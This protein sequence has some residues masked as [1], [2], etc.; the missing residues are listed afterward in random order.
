MSSPLRRQCKITGVNDSMC[1]SKLKELLGQGFSL[2]SQEPPPRNMIFK[3]ELSAPNLAREVHLEIFTNE[4]CE[5]KASRDIANNFQD[6]CSKIET[7][8]KEAVNIVSRGTSMRAMR[9]GRILEYLRNLS[10]QDEVNR[11]VIVTLCDVVLDLIVT[12]KLSTFRHRRQDLENESIGAKIGM[13]KQHIPVYREQAMRDIRDLRNKVVHG[14]AS[15]AEEE[16]AIFAQN[17]TVDI[18]ERF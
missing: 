5:I 4:R 10:T 6:V 12:E 2:V 14:G 15:T 8:L 13:L 1:V 9:A 17:A 7:A 11:M 18:F 16:E 3:C